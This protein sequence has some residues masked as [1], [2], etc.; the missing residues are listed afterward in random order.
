MFSEIVDVLGG[1]PRILRRYRVLAESLEQL[2]ADLQTVRCKAQPMVLLFHLVAFKTRNFPRHKLA[3]EEKRRL[4][5]PEPERTVLG[6]LRDHVRLY[7]A[8]AVKDAAVRRCHGLADRLGLASLFSSVRMR[9]VFVDRAV[10]IIALQRPPKG[11]VI[12]CRGQR[13][14]GTVRERENTL[15]QPFAETVRTNDQPAAVI[16]YGPGDDL[17]SGC[18]SAVDHHDQRESVHH[19]A[20]RLKLFAGSVSRTALY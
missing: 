1:Q 6:G 20:M 18:R 11:R 5:D 14:P 2:I 8:S 19:V 9:I 4:I 7:P 13:Q 12:S 16:L 17:R 15:H 10:R 3:D